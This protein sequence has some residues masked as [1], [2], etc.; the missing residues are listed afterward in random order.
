MVSLARIPENPMPLELFSSNC[1]G[2]RYIPQCYFGSNQRTLPV[3]NHWIRTLQRW[4]FQD[5]FGGKMDKKTQISQK[6]WVWEKTLFSKML[7]FSP[8]V[9]KG[10]ILRAFWAFFWGL[11]ANLWSVASEQIFLH[12]S[13]F[14]RYDFKIL[15]T[16][17][18]FSYHFER[19]LQTVKPWYES[20]RS[21][22]VTHQ[23]WLANCF[24]LLSTS[25]F[26]KEVK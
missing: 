18:F 12:F 17:S 8:L 2:K 9:G 11:S 6:P 13:T 26:C 1:M 4:I 16:N 22:H 25:W 10:A 5:F 19:G 21:W 3:C 24:P 23:F 15:L 7:I 14:Y 20:V